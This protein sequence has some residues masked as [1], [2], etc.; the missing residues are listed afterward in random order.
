MFPPRPNTGTRATIATPPAKGRA[1]GR[2]NIRTAW[3]TKA[4][5]SKVART[6]WG[7]LDT[8][9]T[10]VVTTPTGAGTM[11]RGQAEVESHQVAEL[12]STRAALRKVKS[13]EGNRQTSLVIAHRIIT[14]KNAKDKVNDDKN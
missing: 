4:T 7:W 14:L 10:T 2:P 12:T 8:T 3:T 1:T 13:S 11:I 5:T 9:L 6:R